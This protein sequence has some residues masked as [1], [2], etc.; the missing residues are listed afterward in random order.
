MS[1]QLQTKGL[2]L[3][4]QYFLRKMKTAQPDETD[5]EHTLAISITLNRWNL[6]LYNHYCICKLSSLL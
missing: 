2:N 4:R 6:V 1:E 3:N 5:L